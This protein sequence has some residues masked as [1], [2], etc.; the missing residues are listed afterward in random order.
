MSR[1]GKFIPGGT[2]RK[3]GAIGTRTG[4]I[5]APTPADAAAGAPAKDGKKLFPKGSSLIKPVAKGQRIPILVMSA[6]VACLLVSFA[7]YEFGL[8]P[9]Q[10]QTKAAQQQLAD[11]QA[12]EKKAQDDLLKQQAAQQQAAAAARATVTID[13]K[14]Q[15]ATV[16]IGNS[17]QKTPANFTDVIPGK[18][19]VTIQ[20][21]GYEDYTK[22]ENVTSDKP[23]DL[24]VIELVQKMGNLTVTTSE[25]DA[26]YTMTGPGGY[27][28]DGQLP[29]KFQNLP[30]G[31]YQLTATL[32]DWTLPPLTISIHDRDN[33]QKEIK[34]PFAS[35]TITSV[36][37]GAI[38]RNGHT[39][40][41]PTPASINHLR[42]GTLNLSVDLPPYTIQRFSLPVPDAGN[43]TKSV[44]L[45]MD[46]DFIG[47]CGM[48]M[49][50]IPDGSF[51]AGKY[52]VRQGEFEAVAGYNPSTFRRPNRPVE[53]ISWEAAV[54]FC[55][56]L[57]QY[58]RKAGKL[59]AGYHYSLPT[60]SQWSQFSADA[61]INQAVMSRAASLSSTLDTGS[62]EPNK[63]GLYDTLGN[64]WEWC[65]DSF[66]DRGNHSLRGGS[67][68]SSPDNFPN[69]ETRSAGAPKY[70]DRFTGFRVVL[71]PN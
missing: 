22:D 30:V 51:W 48:P 10:E 65:L 69:A 19:T 70:S 3:T 1:A 41:G 13:S 38:L 31:D 67:W 68:L 36:P 12:A 44:T 16:T 42:P 52:E 23:T 21:D 66:D 25:T 62:S 5:R 2:G 37:P 33:L 8:R 29:D 57:N 32:H 11:A 15:G 63:Y 71:V 28:H 26:T 35:V 53:T 27:T 46:K 9:L 24:G 61:D 18:I 40:I 54:A 17:H 45:T 59:P 56:K 34:F 4:P 60:E 43:I 39:V 47:A 20:A 58:E 55:D 49:V 50:W 6:L 64:V 14:P 7:W